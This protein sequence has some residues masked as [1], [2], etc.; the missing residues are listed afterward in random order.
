MTTPVVHAPVSD[1]QIQQLVQYIIAVLD[2]YYAQYEHVKRPE[3]EVM[4][5]KKYARLVLARPESRSCYGFVDMGT[6]E[7]LKSASWRTPAKNF[8]RGSI[9][10]PSTWNCCGFSSIT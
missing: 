4:P 7:L 2:K 6:G 5:G 8:A 9:H 3:V 10:N 1:D